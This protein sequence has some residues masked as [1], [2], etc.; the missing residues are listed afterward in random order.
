[1]TDDQRW[2]YGSKTFHAEVH[3][4]GDTEWGHVH[5]WIRAE[6]FVLSLPSVHSDGGL[7]A[8]DGG[9]GERRNVSGWIDLRWVPGIHGAGRR[10]AHDRDRSPDGG[11]SHRAGRKVHERVSGRQSERAG[12]LLHL[13]ATRLERVVQRRNPC[14]LQLLRSGERCEVAPLRHHS[15]QLL[16]SGPYEGGRLVH[17][18]GRRTSV[19][20]VPGLRGTAR[21][22]DGR[23]P[24][25]RQTRVD[26]AERSSSL[27]CARPT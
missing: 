14:L 22:R 2:G 13:R 16:L 23:F 17:P 21:T 27:V 15:A 5:E 10:P 12:R 8:N 1:M 18:R 24:G 3:E 20:P 19:L 26:L 25:R 9:V 4:T 7:L 11:L 6:P